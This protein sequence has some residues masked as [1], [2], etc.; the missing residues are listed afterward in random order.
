MAPH[1]ILAEKAVSISALRN[2]STQTEGK[3]FKAQF[4]P[5]VANLVKDFK[6]NKEGHSWKLL[7][8][9]TFMIALLKA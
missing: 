9:V 3:S 1:I 2:S 5:P 7:D 6:K 4:R 8:A